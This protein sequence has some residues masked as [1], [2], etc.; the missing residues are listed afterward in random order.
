MRGVRGAGLETH[1]RQGMAEGQCRTAGC[2]TYPLAG[3]I[4]RSRGRTAFS[5]LRGVIGLLHFLRLSKRLK[6]KRI[7][8]VHNL[9]QHEGVDWVDRWGYRILARH[10]DMV[11]CHSQWAAEELRRRD[12]PRG[13]LVVMPYGNYGL[14]YPEAR[15][16]TL[17]LKELGLMPEL[18]MVC[19]IGNLRGYKG[20]EIVCAAVEKLGNQFQLVI[21]GRP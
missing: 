18:P 7:W 20:L 2:H 3:D 16:R 5:R 21:G 17:V 13:R 14:A 4:W 19:C 6:I 15:P 8:T 1:D 9:A 12:R 11:I 10:S